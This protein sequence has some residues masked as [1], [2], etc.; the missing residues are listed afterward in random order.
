MMIRLPPV[1]FVGCGNMAGALIAGWQKAEVDFTD[2]L[3]VRPSGRPVP[4]LRT[5]AH[6]PDEAAP[7]RCLL[8]FKPQSLAAIAPELAP[9]LSERTVLV[10]MLAGVD[11]AT[12]RNWFPNVEA[13]VRIMPN[14]PVSERDGVTGL[15]SADAAPDLRDR[16]AVLFGLIGKAIWLD[17]ETELAAIGSLAGAGPAYVARFIA[18][19][20]KAGVE[21]GLDP[22]MADAIALE[23]VL[24]TAAMAKA[25]AEN[26]DSIAD[27]V[28]S[29]NGTTEAGLRILD[30]ELDHLIDQTLE[31]ASRRGQELAE[32]ARID[33]TR[34]LA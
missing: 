12:L 14:L 20:A 26:M 24:G 25:R 16:M 11:A 3:A 2:C 31:A 9:R 13:V 27:R 15:Y 19:L 32:A 28:A 4:G 22:A 18:A 5:L 23:T 29:P 1:W 8:G 34:P 7:E 33:L 21:R 30:A 6:L 10:S 17:S